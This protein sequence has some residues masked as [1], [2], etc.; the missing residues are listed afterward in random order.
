MHLSNFIIP[1]K[2]VFPL[3]LLTLIFKQSIISSQ[4]N[5]LETDYYNWFDSVT[6]HENTEVYNGILFVNN[7]NGTK[8][9]HRFFGSQSFMIGC[10]TFDDQTYCN[11]KLKYDVLTD[12]L[13]ITPK[14]KTSKFV[15]E[16]RKVLIKDFSINGH[17]F[18]HISE[19]KEGI[20]QNFGFAEI[21]TETQFQ[22]LIKKYLKNKQEVIVDLEHKY[23]FKDKANYYLLHNETYFPI[24]KANDWINIFPENKNLIKAYYKSYSLL[25]KTDHDSFMKLLFERLSTKTIQ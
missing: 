12:N 3:I 22:M 11:Q 14:N 10:V 2:L 17:N 19:K 20:P 13:L 1:N 21:I 25:Q 5:N 4:E 8:D 24:N 18:I 16:L 23:E 6:G 9:S 15:I 7:F